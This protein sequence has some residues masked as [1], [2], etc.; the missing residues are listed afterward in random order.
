MPAACE[1]LESLERAVAL[2]R[3]GNPERYALLGYVPELYC[4][5]AGALLAA[6][7]A[8][9]AVQIAE[10]AQRLSG[11]GPLVRYTHA[12][13]LIRRAAGIDDPDEVEALLTKD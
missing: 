13:A 10:E 3:A 11:D 6:D 2:V 5:Y 8:A 12:H 7:R 4:L 9:E 1:T